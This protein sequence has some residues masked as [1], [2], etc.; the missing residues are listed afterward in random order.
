[1]TGDYNMEEVEVPYIKSTT[2]AQEQSQGY[3]SAAAIMTLQSEH[4]MMM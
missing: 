4:T 2:S 1:M 3:Q